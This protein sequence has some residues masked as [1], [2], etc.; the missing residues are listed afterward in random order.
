MHPRVSTECNFFTIAFR[1]D[2]RVTPIARHTVTT[3]GNPSGIAATAKATPA[4]KALSQGSLTHNQYSRK[5]TPQINSITKPSHF[6]KSSKFFCSGVNFTSAS[7]IIVA[8]LPTSV[9][10][11]VSVIT[12][13]PRPYVAKVDEKSIFLCSARGHSSSSI[14][15][16]CLFTG[17]LS[18]VNAASSAFKFFSSNI[19]PSAGIISPS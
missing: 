18:P 15:F 4:N 5:T 10:I 16:V 3:A 19:R 11:P 1:L 12:T 14:T 7:D 6:P 17:T 8:I 9:C 2:I 13:F